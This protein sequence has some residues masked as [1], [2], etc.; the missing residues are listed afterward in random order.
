MLPGG[1]AN[2]VLAKIDGVDYNT[3]WVDQSGGGSGFPVVVTPDPLAMSNSLTAPG[4]YSIRGQRLTALPTFATAYTANLLGLLR[5]YVNGT[6]V[7]QQWEA[8]SNLRATASEV[9]FRHYT[10]SGSWSFWVRV[11]GSLA[12]TDFNAATWPGVYDR[13]SGNATNG[14][15]PTVTGV[16]VMTVENGLDVSIGVFYAAQT[17]YPSDG[18][19]SWSRALAGGSW[20]PWRLIGQGVAAGGTAGQML[21]KVDGTSYNT[22]WTNVHDVPAGGTASQTLTKKSATDFDTQW[23]TGSDT[24]LDTPWHVV[25]YAGEP[26]YGNS[27][28][29]PYAPNGLTWSGGRFKRDA[30][31]CVWL[32]GLINGMTG[33]G[34]TTLFTLPA[35]YRPAATRQFP[36]DQAGSLTGI[37]SITSAGVVTFT[38]SPSSSPSWCSV[39]NVTFMAE[40]AQAVNWVRPA[41]T[42]GW[43]NGAAPVGYFVDNA[44]DIHLCGQATG[45]AIGAANPIFTLPG[46]STDARL[47]TVGAALNG[48]ARVDIDV[49]G[50]VYA[51]A[52]IGSGGTWVNL[53]GIVI[54]NPNGVWLEPSALL[55]GWAN[56][57]AAY[58]NLAFCKNRN[59]VAAVRGLIKSGAGT[60]LLG[61]SIPFETKY[62]QLF[63]GTSSGGAGRLDFTPDGTLNFIG[64]INGG[65]NAYV[66]VNGRW[67]EEIAMPSPAG[68]GWT[69]FASSVTGTNKYQVING[70]VYVWV[71]GS[72]STTSGTVYNLST[73]PLPVGY[74]PSGASVRT[75]AYFGGWPGTLTVGPDGVVSCIQNSG[76]T[77]ASVS[78]MVIYPL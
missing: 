8:Q 56:Y 3:H 43:S 75:G 46:L 30:A 51:Y 65:T 45:G 15:G 27:S 61:G 52:W 13:I 35:G 68:N 50:G 55:N 10:S 48:A 70:V 54:A 14:P 58:P 11:T 64:F 1:T 4:L 5:V 74:R 69:N 28:L 57:G 21:T 49:T 33:S 19:P 76:A 72:F 38:P 63:L 59:G 66:S 73:A 32:D 26:P 23:S 29:I 37:I 60:V 39:H 36:V 7:Y 9:W 20:T 17:W 2:Q 47:L 22:Q 41:L 12:V 67:P 42:G 34:P 25:G 78:G 44:G 71:D 77:R 6:S 62:Q 53:D 40:D 18:S 31:G 16:L 24:T